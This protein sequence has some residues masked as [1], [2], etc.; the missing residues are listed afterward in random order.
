MSRSEKVYIQDIIESIDMIFKYVENRTELEFL[1]DFMLQDA[2]IRRFE[3]IGEVAT[4]IS[5]ELKVRNPE[6]QW[7]LM[8]GMRNKLIH[9]Y[10][11]VLQL[12]I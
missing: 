4:K 6:I 9:E 8:K 11:G 12:S 10:F 2:V 7:R 5:E 3:I 1:N